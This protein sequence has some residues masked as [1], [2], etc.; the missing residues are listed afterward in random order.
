MKK[1]YY[2]IATFVLLT[3]CIKTTDST[4]QISALEGMSPERLIRID[5]V[6][7]QAVENK[8]IP[9]AVAL[10]TRNGQVVYENAFGVAN[11]R[12]GELYENDDIF[13]IASMT[14]AVTSL[15]VLMLWEE[16]K[17][18]LDDPIS[19]YIPSFANARILKDFNPKDSSYTSI[20]ATK[21]ITIR[22]LLTHTSGIGY[23][24]IDSNIQMKAIYK[25]AGLTDIFA[26]E[27]NMKETVDLIAMQPLHHEPGA[28]FTY[29]LSLDVLGYFV[30]VISG[31][32]FDEFLK[33]RIFSPLKM[34]DTYFTLPSSHQDRL[35][36]VLTR[37]KNQWDVY[38][39]DVYDVNFPNI[40]DKTFFSGGAGLSSTVSDYAKFLYV[41][42]NRGKGASGVQII[43][44]KTTELV[45]E[46][47][48][49]GI[50]PWEYGLGFQI[51]SAAEL[52]KGGMG[53]QGTLTWGGYF[54]TSYF[55]DPKE[56]VIGVIYKQTFDIGNDPTSQRFRELVFQA[57][58][59]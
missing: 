20:P 54:N 6:L 52:S 59:E 51:L 11:P 32:G 4:S 36:P 45:F 14:K 8:V 57:V 12:T 34:E 55:A 18:F 13:R 15:A 3:S 21:Q 49:K 39:T 46:N 33:E 27:T 24:E 9:G 30:E 29:S 53:S 40:T 47:Q 5:S 42:I 58:V 17:F 10:V 7:N 48:L 37:N 35:V 25:K 44:K 22:N 43:G 26:P 2:F 56:K 1:V 41:F 23:G 19:A 50:A 38:N 28:A 31:Q 16:G